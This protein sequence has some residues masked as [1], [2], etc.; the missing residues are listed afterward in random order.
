[1]KKLTQKSHK[2]LNTIGKAAIN[3]GLAYS[4]FIILGTWCII[5]FGEPEFPQ[6]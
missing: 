4:T 3:L 6:E 5:F 1:M 2:L